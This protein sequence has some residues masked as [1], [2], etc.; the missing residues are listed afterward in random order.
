MK[1]IWWRL[2]LLGL[3]GVASLLLMPLER[4]VAVPIDPMLLRL[5]SAVQPALLTVA[6]AALGAWA[7]PKVGLDAPAVRAWAEGR[8]VLPVLRGRLAMALAVGALA[9]VMILGFGELLR[10]QGLGQQMARM[11]VPLVTR[12]LYGGVTEEVLTRW[13]LMSLF[14]WSAWRLAGRGAAV[15]AW[16]YWAGGLAAAL[17]FA[18]GHLPMLS[19]LVADPPGWL[20]AAILVGNTVPGLLFGWLYWRR[21]LEAAMIA[22]GFAHLTAGLVLMLV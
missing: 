6:A 1:T 19:L 21:G 15:A 13:G 11:E 18:A 7:A 3:A 16:C 8:P 14:V 12:L 10:V 22:H 5:I 17:L 20:V 2:S 4:L 9:G